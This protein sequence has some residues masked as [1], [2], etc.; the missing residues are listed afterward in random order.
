MRQSIFPGGRQI[1]DASGKLK[2]T[3]NGSVTDIAPG[4][5]YL[6]ARNSTAGSSSG[7]IFPTSDLTYSG[8]LSFF[9]EN[10]ELLVPECDV[11]D[12]L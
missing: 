3:V 5:F 6:L 12:H 9:G 11:A 2:I 8:A 4:G 1:L 10:L 7:F